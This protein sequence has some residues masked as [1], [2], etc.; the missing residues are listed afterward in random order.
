VVSTDL[1]GGMRMASELI[2]PSVVTFLDQILRDRDRNL[3]IEELELPRDSPIAGKRVNDL[4]NGAMADLL[5][6]AVRAP[7][8]GDYVYNPPR[9]LELLEGCTLIVMGTPVD[10]RR[11]RLAS[12]GAMESVADE[13]G[14]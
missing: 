7:D 5:L 11:A 4:R 6:L 9:E 2:R 1:I 13:T 3:R 10:M 14:M 12:E 8:G